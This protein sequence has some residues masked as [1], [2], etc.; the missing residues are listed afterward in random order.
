MKTHHSIG[1]IYKATNLVNGKVYIGLTTTSLNH[2][3]KCHLNNAFKYNSHFY[4]YIA[5]R[6]YGKE[7]FSWEIIDEADMER[8]NETLALKEIYWIAYYDCFNNSNKGYNQQPGGGT[9]VLD[10]NASLK[11][12]QSLKG[13]ISPMKGKVSE[14]KGKTL[15]E[16]RGSKEKA[17]QQKQKISKSGK[18]RVVSEATR[19]KL[20]ILSRD[21][22]SKGLIF[23]KEQREKAD[24]TNRKKLL[25]KL[26]ISEDTFIIEYRNQLAFSEI[27]S[28]YNCTCT[29]VK[30]YIKKYYPD[31]FGKY[32]KYKKFKNKTEEQKKNCAISRYRKYSPYL[33][34]N[35]ESVI[36]DYLSNTD[37]NE[38][39]IKY[40]TTTE[41][42]KR[43]LKFTLRFFSHFYQ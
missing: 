23:T 38:M 9:G 41:K 20:S 33:Y 15:E 6:K 1:I 11:K 5:L 8:N 14:K 29:I 25:K 39:T 34:E 18:G 7:N 31:E 37:L 30:S 27:A 24:E 10:E 13:R 28:K 12:K 40:K 19:Q 36:K 22:A 35:I 17:D 3:R 16:I 26:N 43:F 2:R 21:R 32:K 42:L 4:F